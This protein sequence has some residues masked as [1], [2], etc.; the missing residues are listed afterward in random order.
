MDHREDRS[1]VDSDVGS[2]WITG[3]GDR[4]GVGSDVGSV[5]ITGR[6]D[7]SGVGSDAGSVWITGRTGQ[8]YAVMWGVCGSQGGQVRSRQ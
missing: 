7:R 3:R 1:G 4:S 6:G 2:V 5:W 8:E